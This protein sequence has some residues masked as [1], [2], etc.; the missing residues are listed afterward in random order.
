M[1][2]RLFGR[3]DFI[4][5][6]IDMIY[7]KVG[8]AFK[9]QVLVSCHLVIFGSL[10]P[11]KKWTLTLMFKLLHDFYKG[12]MNGELISIIIGI[13]G[14]EQLGPGFFS[15]APNNNTPSLRPWIRSPNFS[16]EKKQT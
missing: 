9:S 14:I 7:F 16:G 1:V 5:H 12:A 6:F 13:D 11:N 10:S 15:P 3:L 8:C 4:D 2:F